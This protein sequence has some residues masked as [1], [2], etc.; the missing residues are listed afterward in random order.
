VESP[1]GQ[2]TRLEVIAEGDRVTNVV[3]GK[4]VN[5]GVRSSLSEGKILVQ[6][7][8]AEIYFRRIDL[9]PLGAK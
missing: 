1:Y 5:E 4:V 2:W 6:C 3:N 9:E 8:G 7:E